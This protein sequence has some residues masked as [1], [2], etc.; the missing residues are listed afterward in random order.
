MCKCGCNMHM[1]MNVD[2]T[3][4]LMCVPRMSSHVRACMR[5][6]YKFIDKCV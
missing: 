3:H 6:L 2:D 4:I 1:Y 5:E